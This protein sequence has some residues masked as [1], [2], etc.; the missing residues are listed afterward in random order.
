MLQDIQF[1]ISVLVIFILYTVGL[2]SFAWKFALY[3]MAV[4]GKFANKVRRKKRGWVRRVRTRVAART[5]TVGWEDLFTC[6]RFL[7]DVDKKSCH[8]S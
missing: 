5:R 8:L 2:T 7:P 3:N 4:L 1:Q 6:T